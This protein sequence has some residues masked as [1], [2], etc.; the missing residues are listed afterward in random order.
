MCVR[1]CACVPADNSGIIMLTN[2]CRVLPGR[3]H[4]RDDAG[5][6]TLVRA[7]LI[8]NMRTRIITNRLHCSSRPP[9]NLLPAIMWHTVIANSLAK[10]DLQLPELHAKLT[11]TETDSHTHTL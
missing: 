6:A 7:A 3:V 9:W 4:D 10:Y 2:K 1:A 8:G 5:R 11:Q